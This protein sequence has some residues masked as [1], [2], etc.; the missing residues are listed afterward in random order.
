MAAKRS[1]KSP[2]RRR[3]RDISE[4][5]QVKEHIRFL[6]ATLFQANCAVIVVDVEGRIT[7]WNRGAERLHGFTADEVYGWT[8]ED[9]LAGGGGVTPI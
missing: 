4:R 6:N 5:R 7:Y 1:A 9:V 2:S 3:D 8:V